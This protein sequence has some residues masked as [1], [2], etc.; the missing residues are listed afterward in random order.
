MLCSPRLAAS[1]RPFLPLLL[2]LAAA[3]Q[4]DKAPASEAAAPAQQLRD[5]LGRAVVVPAQPRRI[6]AL[7]ASM[8]EMLYAVADTATI[9]ARTQVCDYPAAALR[10]P[11]INSYPLDLERLVALRPDVVFT[12]DGITSQADAQ[13]LQELGIPVYYQHYTSVEDIFRGLND[14][15]RIL[16]RQPQARRL[17]DSLRTELARLTPGPTAPSAPRVLAITW[18][19]PIYVYGQ[20]TLFTDKIAIAGGQNAVQEKFAQPYPALTREYVLKLNP[21]I[22]IGGTFGKMDSTFFRLYPELKRIRAYQT[23]RIYRV[24]DDLMSRPTPRVVEGVRELKQVVSGS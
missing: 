21:D 18:S 11:V 15:G 8:T 9:V 2:L 13:R 20:N 10:K 6:M 4:P 24:T 1:L 17:T 7:A 3:C 23:R 22:I 5:D 16:G 14:L 19:D 12:T